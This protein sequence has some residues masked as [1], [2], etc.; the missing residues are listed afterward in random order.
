MKGLSVA[1]TAAMFLVGGGIITHG[2]PGVHTWIKGLA[3]GVTAAPGIGGALQWL[4]L[5]LLEAVAGILAGALV[6]AVVTGARRVIRLR[7]TA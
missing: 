3:D 7:T 6:L 5:V 4:A 2:I 1:G